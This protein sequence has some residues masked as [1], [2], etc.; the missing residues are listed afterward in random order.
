MRSMMFISIVGLLL[1]V[2]CQAP[3]AGQAVKVPGADNSVYFA[4]GQEIDANSGFVFSDGQPLA[5][6]YRDPA[7]RTNALS[8][9]NA[10]SMQVGD[11]ELRG[12][13]I[14]SGQSLF[15]QAPSQVLIDADLSVLPTKRVRIGGLMMSSGQVSSHGDLVLESNG[16]LRLDPGSRVHVFGDI[17]QEGSARKVQAESLAGP[18]DAYVCVDHSGV[19]Y[20]SLAPCV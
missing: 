3:Q 5:K 9:G 10:G 14:S 8:L 16:D 4:N 2:A 13:A 19:L 6:L 11:L 7:T 12:N 17:V 1:L 20:R 15:L 18:K